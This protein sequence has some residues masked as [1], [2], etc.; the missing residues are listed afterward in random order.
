M[1][2]SVDSNRVPFEKV[3]EQYYFD[4]LRFLSQRVSCREDAEDIASEVFTYCYLNYENYDPQKSAIST[5]LY[6][7]TKSRLKNYYR[8]R[9]S[10]VNLDELENL[11]P[12]ESDMDR[13]VYLEQLRDELLEAIS[14]LPEKQHSVVSMRY[15]E[16]REFNEIAEILGTS[17]GNVRVILSRALDRLET[18]CSDLK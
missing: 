9:R 7:V 3:Y 14:Q 16:K 12:V 15:F 8:A 11:L 18:I 1:I 17:A 6:L 10:Y 13:A 5:W 4:V 2:T